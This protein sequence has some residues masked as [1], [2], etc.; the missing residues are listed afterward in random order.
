MNRSY[1]L[2][3]DTN[4]NTT[5]RLQEFCDMGQLFKLLDNWSKCC[6]MATMIIDAEGNPISKDFGMTEF[7]KMVQST[8]K[9]KASCVST[10]EF[11]SK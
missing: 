1:S 7:C 9:G 2:E 6:G 8:E 4:K 3:G 5:I 10:W 11:K